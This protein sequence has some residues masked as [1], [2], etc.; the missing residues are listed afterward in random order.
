VTL[1]AWAQSEEVKVAVHK[2]S[3]EIARKYRPD[4]LG[5]IVRSAIEG[6][7]QSQKLY[8]QYIERRAEKQKHETEHTERVTIDFS[9]VPTEVIEQSVKNPDP[10][11][12]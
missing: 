4:V 2:L 3:T 6:N 7:P 5:A 8:L 9:Q 1:S 12:R 10:M 11:L